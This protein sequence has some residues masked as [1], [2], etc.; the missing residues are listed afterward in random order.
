M[1]QKTDLE[2][3]N[4]RIE[5]MGIKKGHVAKKVGMH[6][7]QLSYLLNGKRKMNDD[8]KKRLLDYLGL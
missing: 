6:Q 1:S 5:Q 8:Q 4:E 7:V 3:I 2:R